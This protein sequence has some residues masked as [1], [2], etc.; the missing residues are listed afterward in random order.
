MAI[1]LEDT[2]H[3]SGKYT[4]L[5]T[6]Y[7]YGSITQVVEKDKVRQECERLRNALYAGSAKCY[8]RIEVINNETGEI[9]QY[10]D[11]Q[12]NKINF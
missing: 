8:K 6:I 10:W 4:I 5:A 12:D 2:N 11:N 7:T 1:K 3:E 9:R